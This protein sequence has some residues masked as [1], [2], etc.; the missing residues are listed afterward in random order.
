M[1]ESA[2]INKTIVSQKTKYHLTIHSS[3]IVSAI[4][5][6]IFIE[7][8]GFIIDI[9]TFAVM[10]VVITRIIEKSEKTTNTAKKDDEKLISK[11]VRVIKNIICGAFGIIFVKKIMKVFRNVGSKI[12]GGIPKWIFNIFKEALKKGLKK[13]LGNF[14]KSVFL[15][16][17]KF[18][19]EFFKKILTRITVKPLTK[20]TVKPL[21]E[22]TVN[23]LAKTTVKTLAKTTGKTTAMYS[24]PLLANDFVWSLDLIVPLIISIVLFEF[25]GWSIIYKYKKKKM[26]ELFKQDED[27]IFIGSYISSCE[28]KLKANIRRDIAEPL[29]LNFQ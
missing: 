16:R 13:T 24:F 23:P 12:F 8:L 15:P 17:I 2:N 5:G 20:I 26:K 1:K 11:I 14:I 21:A 25:A 22:S 4:S 29:N 6:V 7:Y 10:T 9:F 3:A 18:I 19:V 27:S 28:K